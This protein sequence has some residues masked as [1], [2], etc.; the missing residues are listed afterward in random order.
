VTPRLSIKQ[1]RLAAEIMRIRREFSPAERARL[2]TLR[3]LAERFNAT[4]GVLYR[5]E[6]YPYVRIHPQDRASNAPR[7]TSNNPQEV[8]HS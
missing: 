1:R 7:G 3:E 6:S 5:A 2:P 8:S 4:P